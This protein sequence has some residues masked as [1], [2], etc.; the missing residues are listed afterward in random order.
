MY[1]YTV[2]TPIYVVGLC[3]CERERGERK[4]R[5][6]QGEKETRKKISGFDSDL[7]KRR[8][9]RCRSSQQMKRWF[10]FIITTKVNLLMCLPL[11]LLLISRKI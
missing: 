6:R 3:V 7:L 8:E 1:V 9:S 5:K 10:V 2:R 4:K 11:L